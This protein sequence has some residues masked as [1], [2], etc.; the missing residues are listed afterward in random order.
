MVDPSIRYLSAPIA[1]ESFFRLASLSVPLSVAPTLLLLSHIIPH[2]IPGSHRSAALQDSQA[3]DK[4]KQALQPMTSPRVKAID[5]GG[6]PWI[7]CTSNPHP[8]HFRHSDDDAGRQTG[9]AICDDPVKR[10]QL[11]YSEFP[12]V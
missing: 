7:F 9:R 1:I 2:P 3:S 6:F 4:K 8:T 10:A 5:Y 12:G 11:L